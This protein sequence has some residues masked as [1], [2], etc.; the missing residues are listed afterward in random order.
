MLKESNDSL[1]DNDILVATAG[2]YALR[3]ENLKKAPTWVLSDGAIII[4]QGYTEFVIDVNGQ[5]GPNKWGYDVY[6]LAL[7]GGPNKGIYCSYNLMPTEKGGITSQ[8][9]LTK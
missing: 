1:S 8:E 4:L 2:D 3:T 9:A 7:R 5:K 6:R